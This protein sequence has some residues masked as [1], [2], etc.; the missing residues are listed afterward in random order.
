M[1]T[2]LAVL[3][4]VAR[5][6]ASAGSRKNIDWNLIDEKSGHHDLSQDGKQLGALD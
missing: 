4:G 3:A 1:P 5:I 2:I 6:S